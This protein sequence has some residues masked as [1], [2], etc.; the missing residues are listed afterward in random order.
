MKLS[1]EASHE[2]LSHAGAMIIFLVVTTPEPKIENP[3]QPE[4]PTPGHAVPSNG[5]HSTDKRVAILRKAIEAVALSHTDIGTISGRAPDFIRLLKPF[6]YTCRDPKW[7]G[8]DLSRLC[9]QE[10]KWACSKEDLVT[11][12]VYTVSWAPEKRSF[13]LKR[14]GQRKQVSPLTILRSRQI[15]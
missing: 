15:L 1:L 7:A 13:N 9:K 6:G 2:E 3:V 10:T 12:G 11:G 14:R 4:T 5:G 8:K